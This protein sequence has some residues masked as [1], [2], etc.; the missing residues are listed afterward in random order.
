MNVLVDLRK[1]ELR[2]VAIGV[3]NKNRKEIKSN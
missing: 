3:L 1:L 2:V